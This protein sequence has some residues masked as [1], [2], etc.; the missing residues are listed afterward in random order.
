[1]IAVL[2][3]VSLS[4]C[5]SGEP[6]KPEWVIH[7]RLVFLSD[8]LSQER[9]PL[10]PDQFRLLFRYIAGDLYGAPTTG[11]FVSPVSD[12]EGG[13]TIDLN[14]THTALLASLEP[15]DFS[16][17]YLRIDPPEARVARLAP[18]L[19]QA[20]GIE[21]VGRLEWLDPRDKQTLLLLYLDRPA[22]ITGQAAGHGRI[23]RYAIRATAAD[24]VWV[25]RE[26]NG[27]E[28]VYTV[29]PRPATVLLAV[30]P[31]SEQVPRLRRSD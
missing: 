2:L 13:F 10:E 22:T 8:D 24:Y 21:Q 30:R 11:D 7:S 18:E 12:P 1:V 27:N 15:T 9:P 29:R 31:V 17:S 19:L 6:D 28:D 26:I 23:L 25:G 4:G 14:R 20:D 3:L 16:L 5:G